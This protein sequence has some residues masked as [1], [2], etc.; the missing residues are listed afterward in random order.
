MLLAPYLVKIVKMWRKLGAW[1]WLATQNMEDFPNSAKKLLGMFEWC[2]AMVCPKEQIE[3]IA[4]FKDLTLEQKSMLL[5]AHKEP[6]KYTE[7]VIIADKVQAL[8]RNVPPPIAL[9]L[10]M[11]EKHEK[12]ERAKIMEEKGCSELEAVLEIASNMIKH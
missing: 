7:G 5:A 3:Q 1:L 9:A 10:A 8:F 2:I 12:R 11:T 4:R 6:G